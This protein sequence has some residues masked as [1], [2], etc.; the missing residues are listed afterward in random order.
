[1][2]NLATATT[3]GG[4]TIPSKI[5]M[6]QVTVGFEFEFICP[7]DTW[8]K[9]STEV[10]ENL[11]K[12]GEVSRLYATHAKRS[13]RLTAWHI[14]GDS[15]IGGYNEDTQVGVE[16]VSPPIPVASMKDTLE[17]VWNVI[18]SVGGKT[19][20]TCGL[21][22]TVFHPKIRS[23][24]DPVKMS[25]FLGDEKI[26]ARFKRSD[27]EYARN[28]MEQ[29]YEN[30]HGSDSDDFLDKGFGESA[31]PKSSIYDAD[32]DEDEFND[33][34]EDL[35]ST[36]T[37]ADRYTMV[38]DVLLARIARTTGPL[39]K[40]RARL[41]SFLSENDPQVEAKYYSV[42]LGKISQ[43]LVEYRAIGGDYLEHSVAEIFNIGRRLVF[44][45]LVATGAVTSPAI[46]KAYAAFLYKRL[47]ES[48]H[49][50]VEAPAKNLSSSGYKYT[51]TVA[52]YPNPKSMY[53]R[54][55]IELRFS[56]TP[57]HAAG[58]ISVISA[59]AELRVMLG[60]NKSSEMLV[61]RYALYG[62]TTIDTKT[63]VVGG[64]SS[65]S[66]QSEVP[67]R[68]PNLSFTDRTLGA[69][70]IAWI[71]SSIRTVRQNIVS[72]KYRDQYLAVGLE[73]HE[74]GYSNQQA[75]AIARAV[76]ESLA[77]N[78][79]SL[80]KFLAELTVKR[81]DTKQYQERSQRKGVSDR[82]RS[83][84]EAL[85]KRSLMDQVSKL[86]LGAITDNMM[87]PAVFQRISDPFNHDI[88][89]VYP[90]GYPSGVDLVDHA[91]ICASLVRISLIKERDQY[92]SLLTSKL[93]DPATVYPSYPGGVPTTASRDVYDAV[94]QLTLIA[95]S[96]QKSVA[97]PYGKYSVPPLPKI[98]EAARRF[99]EETSTLYLD[100]QADLQGEFKPT[101]FTVQFGSSWGD[102][103]VA[104]QI[105][106]AIVP[107]VVAAKYPQLSEGVVVP[108]SLLSVSNVFSALNSEV[109][110]S[111]SLPQ[112]TGIRLSRN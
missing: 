57:V 4:V 49:K 36:L 39:D 94:Y 107:A 110:W 34:D 37:N 11:G 65:Y 83:I 35:S 38:K 103:S 50:K 74:A 80:P 55:R 20:S 24:L 17:K 99:I 52:E 44:S 30:L 14:T 27:N 13:D 6:S 16:L 9:L 54:L 33:P 58:S 41:L 82:E 63:G 25:L 12:V 1:M 97:A 47:N 91:G 15:S 2:D 112:L 92:I 40:N 31:P 62:G 98:Y 81:M 105:W 72:G 48:T 32:D 102:N 86:K 8:S 59:E 46:D 89:K 67:I 77:K 96:I 43:N 26:L 66:A 78:S 101:E 10:H 100:V 64:P 68:N 75:M 29:V 69:E 71:I 106:S 56:V 23:N 108:T 22:M 21:H 93:T 87:N 109:E 73:A 84:H 70:Q 79:N 53:D 5:D 88:S 95:G 104:Y 60:E 45:I 19:N 42:N 51:A 85:R 76:R 90:S 28:F 61:G 18:S 3:L 111:H 7:E